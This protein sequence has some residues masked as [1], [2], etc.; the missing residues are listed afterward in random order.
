MSAANYNCVPESFNFP[1]NLNNTIFNST[2]VDSAVLMAPNDPKYSYFLNRNLDCPVN[3]SFL[4]FNK[5]ANTIDPN[6]QGYYF[7]CAPDAQ[8]ALSNVK[9]QNTYTTSQYTVQECNSNNENNK[10]YGMYEFLNPGTIF[11]TSEFTGKKWPDV[12]P[13]L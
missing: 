1:G 5:K 13:N 6:V 3:Q 4:V 8:T 2:L 11:V 10:V 7:S 12:L 9:G